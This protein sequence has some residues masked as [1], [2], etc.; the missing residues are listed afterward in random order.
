MFDDFD[1]EIQCEEYYNDL[2]EW[3]MINNAEIMEEEIDD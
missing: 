1:M 3:E 2:D